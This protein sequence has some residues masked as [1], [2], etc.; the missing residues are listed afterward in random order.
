MSSLIVKEFT[1]EEIAERLL[2]SKKTVDNHRQHIMEKT[3]SKSTVGLV[4]FAIMLMVELWVDDLLGG[5][6][7]FAFFFKSGYLYDRSDILTSDY[8]NTISCKIFQHPK[9]LARG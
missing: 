7:N 6:G 5:W 2:I 9:Q 4:K 8:Q 1:R 3:N